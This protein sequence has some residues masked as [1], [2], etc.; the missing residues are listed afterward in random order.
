MIALSNISDDIPDEIMTDVSWLRDNLMCIIG[1]AV[2]YSV[3]SVLINVK[4]VSSGGNRMLEIDVQDSG[5][6]KLSSMQ[7][8]ALFDRPIQ[9]ARENV[10]GMGVGL[11]C[12]GERCKALGGDTGA[13]LRLD[14]KSGTV[15]WFRIPLEKCP[16]GKKATK[17][18]L[19]LLKEQQ[20]EL[21]QQQLNRTILD[22][23][24]KNVSRQASRQAA[25]GSQ[26]IPSL[27]LLKDSSAK[28]DRL[29]PIQQGSHKS[30]RIGTIP[31]NRQ[32]ASQTP[33]KV[34]SK[35]TPEGSLRASPRGSLKV[36][37]RG[38]VSHTGSHKSS[39][40]AAM[41]AT[42]AATTALLRRTFS[43][44]EV[45]NVMKIEGTLT[46]AAGPLSGLHILAVDDSA[47]ILKMMVSD[48]FFCIH[49]SHNISLHLLTAIAGIFSLQYLVCFL[50][51]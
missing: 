14:N 12:M 51:C 32:V 30:N 50:C 10:G 11:F 28:V 8:K 17:S 47:A 1:N 44:K 3:A 16:P 48:M 41:T 38:S 46:V 45:T 13:R 24:N 27:S 15:V 4:A 37:H 9:F 39:V 6:D 23:L 7:L 25:R 35:A 43:S 5:A 19:F 22:E 2:K 34:P 36:S 49:I 20:L 18:E 31:E 40:A 42:A 29:S 33:S 26:E 21:H